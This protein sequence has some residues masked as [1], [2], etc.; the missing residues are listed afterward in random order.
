M[1][2]EIRKNIGDNKLLDVLL[3]FKK[4]NL[5]AFCYFLQPH[6]VKYIINLVNIY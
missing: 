4:I 2:S 1:F 3:T 6:S 5:K